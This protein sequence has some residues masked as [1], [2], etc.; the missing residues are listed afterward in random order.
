MVKGPHLKGSPNMV[1]E[2]SCYRVYG[3]DIMMDLQQELVTVAR[4][5]VLWEMICT[6]V[7]KCRN[8]ISAFGIKRSKLIKGYRLSNQGVTNVRYT[9]I[10]CW[11]ILILVGTLQ[12][13]HFAKFKLII[14]FHGIKLLK[15]LLPIYATMFVSFN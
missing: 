15:S 8:A 2:V 9:Y 3:G 1:E 13:V 5:L 14:L 6:W 7:K 4:R 10:V 11:K 12:I